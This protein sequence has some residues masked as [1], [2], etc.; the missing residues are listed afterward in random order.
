VPPTFFILLNVLNEFDSHGTSFQFLRNFQKGGPL[1]LN[2]CY[3]APSARMHILVAL[4]EIILT[5]MLPYSHS[6]YLWIPK[7]TSAAI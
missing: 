6:S 4:H 1:G 7:H 2:S 5:G 3:I